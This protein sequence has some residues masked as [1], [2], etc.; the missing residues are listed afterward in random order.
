MLVKIFG[1]IDIISG[2]V[3]FLSMGVDPGVEIL[4]FFGLVLL[5]KSSFGMLRDFGSWID[6]LSG[7]IFLLS[8]ILNLPNLIEIIFAILLLQKGFFSLI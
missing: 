2:L 3:M 6:F 4:S 1:A 5:V 8:I 7:I